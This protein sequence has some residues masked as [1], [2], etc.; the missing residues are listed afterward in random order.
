MDNFD[1][2]AKCAI[3]SFTV[4]KVPPRQDAIVKNNEGPRYNGD[5]SNLVNS[6]KPGDTYY[7]D[8]VKARCPGDQ[9]GRKINSM[10]FKIR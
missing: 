3:Q 9:V 1:F 7:F 2:D 8:E 5:V 4:T 10:V 6:A